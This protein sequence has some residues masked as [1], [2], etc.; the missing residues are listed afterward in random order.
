MIVRLRL[1]EVQIRQT[2][3]ANE[4]HS[5]QKKSMTALTLV[6]T[7]CLQNLYNQLKK[8]NIFWKIAF[9][10]SWFTKFV[11]IVTYLSLFD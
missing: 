10:F 3:K 9:L 8:K 7:F 5:K 1:K 2:T 6:N 4:N 11:S